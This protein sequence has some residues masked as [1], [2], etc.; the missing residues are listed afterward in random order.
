MATQLEYLLPLTDT[1][2]EQYKFG[3]S[4]KQIADIHKTTYNAVRTSLVNCGAFKSSRAPARGREQE[5]IELFN[6]GK[7]CN[8]IANKIGV[9]HKVVDKILRDNGFSDRL[10]G[11]LLKNK[12]EEIKDRY[13]AGEHVS[14]LAKYYNTSVQSLYKSLEHSKVVLRHNGADKIKYSQ[15]DHYFD[16]IDHQDK[17]YWLGF[18]FAD[19]YNNE[20]SHTA[21][22][23]LCDEN[24][25]KYLKE[26]I[27]CDRP[28]YAQND[29]VYTIKLRSKHLSAT[30]ASHGCV[31]AKSLI[32]TFPTTVPDDL[33]PHFI[34]GYFDGD[35]CIHNRK[36]SDNY[37]VHIIGTEHFVKEMQKAIPGKSFIHQ[38]S[39]KS[40]WFLGIYR[41]KDVVAFGDWLYNDA[42][43]YMKRKK[44]KFPSA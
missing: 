43:R 27:G 21:T 33:I 10:V 9:T 20:T 22:L 7:S 8:Q 5:I 36:N 30:L 15:N 35:G 28:V 39:K 34:R 32:L 11:R 3:L 25:V 1:L 23:T 17:A 2:I 18:L 41:K 42:N 13:I 24:E 44:V 26:D 14:S 31:Q 37:V 38:R 12:D 6:S 16:A 19:G 29:R 4:V 40:V